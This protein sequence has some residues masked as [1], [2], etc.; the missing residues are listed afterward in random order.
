MS[1]KVWG[2]RW[3]IVGPATF[4]PSEELA[5]VPTSGGRSIPRASWFPVTDPKLFK[6]P[7]DHAILQGIPSSALMRTRRSRIAVLFIGHGQLPGGARKW[8]S[9]WPSWLGGQG[10]VVVI[11]ISGQLKQR[12]TRARRE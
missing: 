12:G 5:A 8:K 9:A 10:R 3:K 11:T 6:E 4:S 1:A 2:S 7:I